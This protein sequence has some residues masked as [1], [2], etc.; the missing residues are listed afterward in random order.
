MTP[1]TREDFMPDVGGFL[2]NM[3]GDIVDVTFE[4]A[5]GKYADQVMS[6]GGSAKPPVM[7][8]LTIEAPDLERPA[9]QS[10]SIGSSEVWDIAA[11]GKS[12]T[13]AKNPD[14][15]SFRK[16]SSGWTLVEAM[17]TAAGDGDFDKGQDFFIK[18]DAY[19]TEAKFYEGTSWHWATREITYNI[20]DK[21]IKSNPPL[22]EKLLGTAGSAASAAE[23]EDTTALDLVI[24]ELAIGKT[25]MELKKAAIQNPEIKANSKYLQGVVS[26]KKIKELEG[27][28]LLTKDGSG[29]YA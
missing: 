7:M 16:G 21:V 28:G 9:E 12:V 4:L 14:R 23:A 17:I 10:Y 22:P 18:R 19:M 24:V 2:D 8:K 5:S 27:N 20:G 15:K 11:D 25:E 29:K 3:S 26:G 13:G 6:G 1:K